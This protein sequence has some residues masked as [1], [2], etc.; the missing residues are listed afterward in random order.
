VF[1]YTFPQPDCG[2]IEEMFC[3]GR[4]DTVQRKDE[5]MRRKYND[6]HA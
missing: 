6:F 1:T 3:F 2:I 4:C 5:M